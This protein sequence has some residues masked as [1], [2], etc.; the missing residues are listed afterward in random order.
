MTERPAH[1]LYRSFD[2]PP[3]LMSFTA[4]FLQHH[5]SAPGCAQDLNA[6]PL[7]AVQCSPERITVLFI[8]NT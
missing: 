8:Q 5:Y 6:L 4:C 1:S 2:E 3:Q 7:L